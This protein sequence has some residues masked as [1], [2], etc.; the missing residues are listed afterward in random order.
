MAT[1][2]K[3][4]ESDEGF[5]GD[6]KDLWQLVVAYFKQETIDPIK[7]LGRYV[8][9]GLAGSLAV[10][11]GG[12]ML[13]LG[14]LRLLQEETGDAFDGNWS[15]VPYVITLVAAALAAGAAVKAGSQDRRKA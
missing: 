6:V 14:L 7:G 10:G 13:V 2:P 15:F 5:L 1:R 4:K 3:A 12:V 11:L 8:G 9:F